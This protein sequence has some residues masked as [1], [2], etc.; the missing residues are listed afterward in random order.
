MKK[1]HLYIVSFLVLSLGVSSYFLFKPK[2]CYGSE[3]EVDFGVREVNTEEY[4]KYKEMNPKILPTQVE[5]L[6][7]FLLDVREPSEWTAG[8]IEG[9][10]HLPLGEINE[11]STKD[12][13][14]DKDIYVYCRSGKRAGEAEKILRTLGFKN[15]LNIGGVLDWTERGGLLVQ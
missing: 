8:H 2:D 10:T 14:K 15:V 1:S 13:P 6:S 5:S 4:M 3:C 9:A 7:V 12:F 11:E